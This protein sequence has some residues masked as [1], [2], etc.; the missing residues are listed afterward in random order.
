MQ[1]SRWAGVCLLTVCL[2]LAATGPATPTTAP[3][4]HWASVFG[5]SRNSGFS[6]AETRI[7]AGS[8]GSLE[9]VWS[10]RQAG[11]PYDE[12]PLAIGN[13]VFVSCGTDDLCAFRATTGRRLWR[14]AGTAT[15]RPAFGQGL[16][17]FA[18][19]YHPLRF[20]AVRA[21][22]GEQVW[23][24]TFAD[25]SQTTDWATVRNGVVYVGAA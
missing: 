5:D 18:A 24:R 20:V 14:A 22:T 7:G 23:S 6:T 10:R 11:L 3:N 21:D 13:R 2:V 1:H 16:V 9:P 4:V 8:V 17:F 19:Q 25:A 12:T 15:G